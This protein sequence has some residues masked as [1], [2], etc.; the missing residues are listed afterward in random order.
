MNNAKY[1]SDNGRCYTAVI[2]RDSQCNRPLHTW[3][4]DSRTHAPND[5]DK[6]YYYMYFK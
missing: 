3:V 5:D 1:Y 4:M 2:P 6:I